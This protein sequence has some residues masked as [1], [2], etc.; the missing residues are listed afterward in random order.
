MA[1]VAVGATAALA[2]SESSTYQVDPAHDGS[3][4]FSKP[5]APPLKLRW[6]AHLGGAASYPVVVGNLVIAMNA[7]KS[8]QMTALEIATGKAVWRKTVQGAYDVSYLA[9]DNGK[10]FVGTLEE[11]LQAFQASNGNFLWVGKHFDSFGNFIPVASG[12]YVYGGADGFGT[13][14]F[15]LNES[16]GA[17]GWSY[18][19]DGG[20]IGGT[21]A[22][23]MLYFPAPQNV[24]GF[25][26]SSGGLAWKYTL[27]GDGGGG[28]IA[29]YYGG[30]LY[31][32]DANVIGGVILDGQTGKLLGGLGGKLTPAFYK[33]SMYSISGSSLVASNIE[34]GN[35]VWFFTPPHE[36]ATPPIVING[37]V[38]SIAT[39]GTLYINDGHSGKLLQSVKVC[40]GAGTDQQSPFKGLAAGHNTLFVPCGNSLAAFAP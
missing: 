10:V 7:R 3:V 21:L 17:T 15:K 1:A 22:R 4:T 31:A 29:A 13:T 6:Q 28:K 12:G 25:V 32:Q 16:D 8:S 36:I 27:G 24:P 5:F 18:L 14:V 19:L 2:D 37:N 11:P 38:Y 39:D 34:T 35:V 30:R 23:G 40:I 33:Q 20:G 9:S 26:A